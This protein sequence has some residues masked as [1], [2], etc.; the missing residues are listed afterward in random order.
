M[1]EFPKEVKFHPWI[2]S[3]Y[4]DSDNRFGFRLLVLGESHYSDA[5]NQDDMDLEWIAYRNSN[6]GEHVFTRFVVCKWGQDKNHRFF[7]KTANVL[8]RRGK[9]NRDE[10]NREIWE[11]VAY[12]NYVS[13]Y[14]PWYKGD[15]RPERPSNEQWRQSKTPFEMVLEILKPDAVLMLSKPLTDWMISQHNGEDLKIYQPYQHEQINFVGIPGSGSYDKA[16]PAFQELIKL[17]KP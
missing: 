2:G 3:Y 4:W 10:A 8:L 13:S 15:D 5:M 12:Y 14:V 11:H 16:I 17:T 1:H 7:T 9:A 6:G